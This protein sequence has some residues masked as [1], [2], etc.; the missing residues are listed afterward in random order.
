MLAYAVRNKRGEILIPRGAGPGD[1][2]GSHP[3]ALPR[4]RGDDAGAADLQRLREGARGCQQ[5]L[6]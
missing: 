4:L 3:P 6:N 1:G 5:R 2:R